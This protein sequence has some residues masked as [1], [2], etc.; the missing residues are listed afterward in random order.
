MG[1]P[2]AVPGCGKLQHNKDEGQTVADTL[3]DQIDPSKKGGQGEDE[4]PRQI[5]HPVKMLFIVAADGK[6]DQ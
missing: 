4:H 3:P 2:V 6:E 5:K 1:R